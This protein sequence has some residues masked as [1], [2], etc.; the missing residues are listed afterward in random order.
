[1]IISS[2][3]LNQRIGLI[4]PELVCLNAS[5]WDRFIWGKWYKVKGRNA[6][7]HSGH[8]AALAWSCWCFSVPDTFGF[9]AFHL[10]WELL[11]VLYVTPFSQGRQSLSCCLLPG[12]LTNAELTWAY[13]WALRTINGLVC[14]VIFQKVVKKVTFFKSICSEA[15]PPHPLPNPTNIS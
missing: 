10:F 8:S 3:P 7:T 14:T 15:L 2:A 12:T 9:P 11:H 5:S 1:M 4:I 13:C 6:M